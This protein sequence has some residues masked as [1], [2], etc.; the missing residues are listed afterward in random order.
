M[1]LSLPVEPNNSQK[2]YVL[3]AVNNDSTVYNKHMYVNQAKTA[4]FYLI[5]KRDPLESSY[6]TDEFDRD[7]WSLRLT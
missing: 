4:Q 3:S 1:L 7:S 6:I 2:K 5:L